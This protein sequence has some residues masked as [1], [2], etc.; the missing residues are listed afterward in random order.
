MSLS[1]WVEA[2]RMSIVSKL[3][4]I[5][6]ESSSALERVCSVVAKPGIV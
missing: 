6:R 5:A 2:G 3:A 4:P 1:I